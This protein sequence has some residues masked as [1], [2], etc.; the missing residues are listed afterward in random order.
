M[1][2]L[3]NSQCASVTLSTDVSKADTLMVS[4]SLGVRYID[5]PVFVG[6]SAITVPVLSDSVSSVPTER[7]QR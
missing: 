1:N 4:V 7:T 3:N 2:T 5:V 6:V